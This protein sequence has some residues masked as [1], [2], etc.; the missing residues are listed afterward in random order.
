MAASIMLDILS[1]FSL[2]QRA[3]VSAGLLTAP[4]DAELRLQMRIE[5]LEHLNWYILNGLNTVAR[6]RSEVIEEQKMTVATQEESK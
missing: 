5:E 6:P 4:K 1:I 2:K 3:I